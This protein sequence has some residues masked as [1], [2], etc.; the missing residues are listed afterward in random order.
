[1]SLKLKKNIQVLKLLQKSKP[2]ARKAILR[3]ADKEL[4]LTICEWIDNILKGNVK[5]RPE[6][7]RKLKRYAVI[8]RKLQNRNLGFGSRK[9]LLIQN[10]G[11]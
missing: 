6:Q 5:L 2:V 8:L 7:Y 4:L 9:K 10:G 11:F 3:T 1:M